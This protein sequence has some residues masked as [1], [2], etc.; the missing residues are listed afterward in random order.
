MTFKTD[1]KFCQ[2]R[3]SSV[4]KNGLV[5]ASVVG[6]ITENCP[7]LAG[8]TRPLTHSLIIVSFHKET[9]RMYMHI[10]GGKKHIISEY[11]I[12]SRPKKSKLTIH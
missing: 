6:V 3:T 11:L 5:M 9:A 7:Q 4:G 12:Y 2:M 10:F 8:L 1:L